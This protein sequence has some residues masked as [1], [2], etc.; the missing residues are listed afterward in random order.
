MSKRIDMRGRHSPGLRRNMST[1]SGPV[2]E[3]RAALD[4]ADKAKGGD[5]WSQTRLADA[6]GCGLSTLAAAE[7]TGTWPL[8]R[9]VQMRLCELAERVGVDVDTFS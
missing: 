9:A 6:A 4:A 1:G 2:F 3:I 5:G 8:S 7:R